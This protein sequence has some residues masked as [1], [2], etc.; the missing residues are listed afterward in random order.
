MG[1]PLLPLV[2][3]HFDSVL[4]DLILIHYASFITIHWGLLVQPSVSTRMPGL[5]TSALQNPD[6]YDV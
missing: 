3:K 5:L 4:A 6:F 2:D 1:A